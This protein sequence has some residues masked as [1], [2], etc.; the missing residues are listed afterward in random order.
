MRSDQIALMITA[1]GNNFLK[2]AFF[3]ANFFFRMAVIVKV[4]GLKEQRDELCDICIGDKRK[5][6]KLSSK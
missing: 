4:S 6:N 3:K 1:C 5:I 2:Y